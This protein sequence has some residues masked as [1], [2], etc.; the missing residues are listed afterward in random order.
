[1]AINNNNATFKNALKEADYIIQN[2]PLGI[3]KKIPNNFRKS[4]VE[5]MNQSYVPNTFDKNKSLGEQNILDETKLILAAIYRDYIV[6]NE[7]KN[8]LVME[9]NKIKQKLEKEKRKKYN[10]NSLFKNNINQDK[11]KADIFPNR[12]CQNK[13]KGFFSVVFNMINSIFK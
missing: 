2:L 13:K 11:T 8:N 6:S 10:P 1:M 7:E 12:I 5:N 3:Q 4:I 9:E